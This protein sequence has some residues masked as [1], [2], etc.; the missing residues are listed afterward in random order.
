MEIVSPSS[1]KHG[2]L[3]TLIRQAYLICS[4]PDY[5]QEE[6]NQIAYVFEE[7]NNYPKWVIKQLLEE[8]KYNHHETRHGVL[9]ITEIKND[10]KF[11]LL[12]LP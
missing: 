12:L 3:K 4:T 6:L 8:V 9:Q 11:H 10:E 5:L 2:T 1:W 7:I